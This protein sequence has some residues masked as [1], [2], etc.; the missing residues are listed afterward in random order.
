VEEEEEG[1][2]EGNNKEEDI[3]VAPNLIIKKLDFAI[4]S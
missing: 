2:S 3:K 1:D 4:L